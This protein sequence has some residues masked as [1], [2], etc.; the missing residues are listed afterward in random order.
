MFNVL[1]RP[2]GLLADS[3]FYIVLTFAVLLIVSLISARAKGTVK[4]KG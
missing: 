2:L 4:N 3:L 1:P